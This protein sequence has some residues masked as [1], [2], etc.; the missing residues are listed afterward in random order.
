MEGKKEK[1]KKERAEHGGQRE[2]KN[3]F[4][5]STACLRSCCVVINVFS[6]TGNLASF[7]TELGKNGERSKGIRIGDG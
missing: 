1:R 5:P 4:D 6:Y 3:F 2:L 7:Y